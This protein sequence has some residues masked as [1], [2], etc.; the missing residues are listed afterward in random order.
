MYPAPRECSVNGS[1]VGRFLKRGKA[2]EERL[3]KPLGKDELGTGLRS[4]GRLWMVI[5]WK[6]PFQVGREQTLESDS[7]LCNH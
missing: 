4:V 2:V 5:G 3:G 7:L 6:Q 1:P